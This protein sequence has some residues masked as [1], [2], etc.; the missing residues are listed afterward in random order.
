MRATVLRMRRASG[1]AGLAVSVITGAGLAVGC[2][3]QT[4][5]VG[6]L[7][8][9][10]VLGIVIVVVYGYQ[11][12]GRCVLPRWVRWS[13]PA[14]AAVGL[15]SAVRV[16]SLGWPHISS[17]AM[18]L[19]VFIGVISVY[20]VIGLREPPSFATF[21][22]ERRPHE[23]ART[24]VVDLPVSEG[25]WVVWRGG[26]SALNHHVW[27]S[28]RACGLDLVRLG[29][30]GAR[31]RGIYPTELTAYHAFG[32]EVCC[33]AAGVVTA[34]AGG[35]AVTVDTGEVVLHLANL[36]PGSVS[37]VEGESV[38]AGQVLGT[39]G[40]AGRSTEPHLHLHAEVS[41]RPVRLRFAGAAQR[42]PRPGVGFTAA[43]DAD[44]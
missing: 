10:A 16:G 23:P 9:L 41:G 17:T 36:E 28:G 15:A 4:S 26:V 2:W 5:V 6:W 42:R 29:S 43:G 44:G 19:L 8:N 22:R 34:V 11:R 3:F 30:D 1:W 12:P 33:P 27:T 20:V 37:V 39:V 13:Y 18:G 25:R 40:S 35:D 38:R 32:S 14:C 7:A 31:A 24:L 21:H